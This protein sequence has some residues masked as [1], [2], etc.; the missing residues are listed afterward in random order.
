MN[1][2]RPAVRVIPAKGAALFYIIF[3]VFFVFMYAQSLLLGLGSVTVNGQEVYGAERQ[4]VLLVM[5]FFLLFPAAYLVWYGRRL[6]PGSPFDFL[7]IGPQG[8]T[9]GGLLGRQYRR[10]DEISGFSVGNIPL[11]NQT[12]WIKVESERPLRFFMGG[13]VRFK[14]FTRRKTRM[15]AIA[16]WLDLVRR[17]YAFGDGNLPPP[18]EA[19]AGWILPLTGDKVPAKARA[20]VIERRDA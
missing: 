20:G 3:V 12:I 4:Q 10:W 11:S 6:L 16:D 2:D 19:F 17:T 1:A 9:V 18:P 15:Q 14:L 13:Y 8:L 7:E 5:S